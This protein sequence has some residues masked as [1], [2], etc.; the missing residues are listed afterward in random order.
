M[1]L[2]P[3]TGFQADCKDFWGG[4][5]GIYYISFT[6]R[7]QKIKIYDFMFFKFT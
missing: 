2:S 1:S 7:I 3:E 5:F 4:S 6:A